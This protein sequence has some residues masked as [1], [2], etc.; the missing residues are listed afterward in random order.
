MLEG[1]KNLKKSKEIMRLVEE[2]S[3]MFRLCLK[4]Y[5][6]MLLSISMPKIAEKL[7]KVSAIVPCLLISL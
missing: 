4:I 2:Q 5:T 7:L 1:T 3:N 6:D